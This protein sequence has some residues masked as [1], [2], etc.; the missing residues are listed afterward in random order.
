MPKVQQSPA[1]NPLERVLQALDRLKGLD[2]Q[3]IDVSKKTALTDCMV[4]VSGSSSRHV[5]TMA[6]NLIT[7]AKAAGFTP[8]GVEGLGSG[9]WVLVD[10]NDV[11]VHVMLPST[12]EFYALERLWTMDAEKPPERRNIEH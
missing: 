2:I 11:V 12:R 1:A 6:I 10:L 8:L 3:S 7:D 4:I 5:K 9:E